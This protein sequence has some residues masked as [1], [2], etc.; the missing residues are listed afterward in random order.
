MAWAISAYESVP[1]GRIS[2]DCDVRPASGDR[3]LTFSWKEIG[4][5][6]VFTP[7]RKGFG[8]TILLDGAKQFD[9]NVSLKY[10]PE[11]LRYELRFPLSAVE[12]AKQSLGP[13]R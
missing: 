10:E 12:A 5:P 8:S 1:N 9:A 4:G 6:I 7:K 3:T 2:I 13:P 11:G